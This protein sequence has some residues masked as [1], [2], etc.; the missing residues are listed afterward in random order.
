MLVAT[1]RMIA[2][3]GA[4]LAFWLHC[5]HVGKLPK[6]AMYGK[7][8]VY[9]KSKNGTK[10]NVGNARKRRRNTSRFVIWAY[11]LRR[12]VAEASVISPN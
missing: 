12:I 4:R 5:K 2:N 3:L 11:Y 7:V 6:I 10:T 9:R 8:N 1:V